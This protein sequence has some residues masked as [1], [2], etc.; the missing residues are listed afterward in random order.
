MVEGVKKLGSYTPIK[1]VLEITSDDSR[2]R[3][4]NE[5]ICYRKLESTL[6]ELAVEIVARE[7]AEAAKTAKGSSH[8]VETDM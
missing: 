4:E 1:N 5:D 6:K 7:D 8:P 2:K 3:K